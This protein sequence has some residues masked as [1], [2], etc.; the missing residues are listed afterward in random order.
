MPRRRASDRVLGKPAG[1]GLILFSLLFAMVINL[2]PWHGLALRLRPDFLLLALLFWTVYEPRRVSIGTAFF[3]GLFMDVADA[4][5][6]G[7]HALAYTLAAYVALRYHR[8]L[9]L[10]SVPVQSFY[11]FVLLV[12]VQAIVLLVRV[13]GGGT[14]VG[15]SYFAAS[16]TAAAV[17]P[18]IFAVLRSSES[19]A[20]RTELG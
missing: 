16:L 14:M 18:V 9:A 6:L 13:I 20:S 2:M 3:F 10:F 8:R 11:V 1:Y 5:V 7:Q 12:A 19:R 4:A 17:W 15:L